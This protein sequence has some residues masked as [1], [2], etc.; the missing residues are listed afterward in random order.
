MQATTIVQRAIQAWEEKNAHALAS[1]LADD[2]ICTRIL[3]QQAL[4]TCRM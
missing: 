1:Y 3:P 2:L 4:S